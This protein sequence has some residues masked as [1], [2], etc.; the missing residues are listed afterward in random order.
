MLIKDNFKCSHISNWNLMSIMS[1]ALDNIFITVASAFDYKIRNVYI[2]AAT[3]DS[4]FYP[5]LREN[6]ELRSC[7]R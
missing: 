5:Y 6:W 2:V 3:V 1:Y 4:A 7:Y